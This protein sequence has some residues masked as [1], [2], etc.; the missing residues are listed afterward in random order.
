M[1]TAPS[2]AL[3]LPEAF[4]AVLV[5]A[6]SADGTFGR[7]EA[8]RLQNVLST[9]PFLEEAVQAGDVNVVERV[10]NLLTDRG[11]APVLAASAESITIELRPTVFA[12]AADLMLADGSI[13]PHEKDFMSQLQRALRVPDATALKIVEVLIIKN[14]A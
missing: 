8:R 9:S 4:A 5:A 3:S 11:L 7:D 10:V 13:D 12:V 14:R 6:I 1:T 2:L